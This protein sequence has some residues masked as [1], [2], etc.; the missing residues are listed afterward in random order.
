MIKDL[1]TQAGTAITLKIEYFAD[2]IFLASN[3]WVNYFWA[4]IIISLLVALLEYLFPWRREQPFF[5]REFWL[6]VFYMFFNFFI[7]S[8]FFT[9]WI[10][11]FTLGGVEALTG[12]DPQ[13]WRLVDLSHLPLALQLPLFFIILDFLQWWGH[14]LLHRVPLLWEFHKVHHSVREMSFPAHLRYHWVENL[15]YVPLK[16]LGVTLFFGM[17]PELAFIVHYLSISIGHLNHANVR[18]TWGPLKYIFNNPVMHLWHHARHL[19]K[20]RWGGVNFG[21]SLS[22]WDYIFKTAYIPEEDGTIP[23]GFPRVEEFPKGFI[24]QELYP[25]KK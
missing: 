4:L 9:S 5:R 24:A 2:E 22:L 23:L 6:D 21:L 1:L 13:Q 14:R 10:A 8:I 12:S 16:F 7:F 3:S 20:E 19:P 15:F 17:P 11:L 18:L 25:L